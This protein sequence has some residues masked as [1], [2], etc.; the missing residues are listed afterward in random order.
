MSGRSRAPRKRR[1]EWRRAASLTN[2][3]HPHA[4]PSVLFPR[5]GDRRRVVDDVPINCRQFTIIYS[6]AWLPP[7]P[8]QQKLASVGKD[9]EAVER[10][11]VH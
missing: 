3:G 7:P 1:C 9:V 10:M 11:H 8:E 2:R 6:G 5:V 4:E